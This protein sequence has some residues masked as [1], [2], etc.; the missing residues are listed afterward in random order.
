MIYRWLDVFEL[1]RSTVAAVYRILEIVC[2]NDCKMH[3]AG[4]KFNWICIKGPMCKN[5]SAS[6][7]IEFAYVGFYYMKSQKMTAV[8]WCIYIYIKSRTTRNE[9]AILRHHI[10]TVA[11]NV[12]SVLDFMILPEHHG[13]SKKDVRLSRTSENRD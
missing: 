1:R 9:A 8:F 13:W 5:L 12:I 3:G 4:Q 11:Q 7:G 2:T 10:S 6:N